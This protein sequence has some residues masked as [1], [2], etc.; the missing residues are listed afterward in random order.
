MPQFDTGIVDSYA[1][2][3]CYRHFGEDD[4]NGQI[5]TM[6]HQRQRRMLWYET[7]YSGE[8]VRGYVVKEA[9]QSTLPVALRHVPRFLLDFGDV[10]TPRTM[11]NRIPINEHHFIKEKPHHVLWD[12]YYVKLQRDGNARLALVPRGVFDVNRHQPP[13]HP[14]A[15]YVLGWHHVG[16]LDP[17]TLRWDLTLA[18]HK[19]F[20][21]PDFPHCKID[22]FLSSLE[23]TRSEPRQGKKER[24]AESPEKPVPLKS[25]HKHEDDS[26][27]HKTSKIQKPSGCTGSGKS[28]Q[29]KG[30]SILKNSSNRYS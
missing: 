19:F 10:R 3:L 26:L 16:A 4:K 13:I 5:A 21:T 25:I 6:S 1:E 12:L 23:N 18:L 15:L 30:M 11:N 9:Y 22:A 7:N 2:F 27:T 24:Q 20:G 8:H 28:K 17:C 29:K 14:E